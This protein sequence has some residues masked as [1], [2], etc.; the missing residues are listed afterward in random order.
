MPRAMLTAVLDEDVA[1]D[2]WRPVPVA[3]DPAGLHFFD[4]TTGRSIPTGR[5]DGEVVNLVA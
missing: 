2:L 4:L 3:L 5:C 1:I